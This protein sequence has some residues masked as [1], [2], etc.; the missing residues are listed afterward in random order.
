MINLLQG[1]QEITPIDQAHHFVLPPPGDAIMDFMNE[2]GYTEARLLEFVQAIQT[3]L[4]DKANLGS[5]TKKGWKDKPHVILYC[6]FTK[7]IICH[8]G[9]THNIHQRLVSPFHLAKEDLR[10]GNLK[11]VPKGEEDEVFGMPIPNGLMKREKKKEGEEY[12]VERAIQMSLE[13]YQAQSLSHVGGVAIREPVVEVTRPLPVVEG[14]GK[15]IATEEQAAQSLLALH[16][17]KKRI[18]DS[19]SPA[20]AE[21]GAD[22]DKTNIREKTAEIDEGQ[23][24]SDPGKTP[25]SRPLPDSSSS[26]RDCFRDLPEADMKEML[27][28]RMF[29]SGSYKSHHEHVALYEALEVSMKRAQRGELLAENAKSRKR[30][31]DYQDPPPP[32][33]DSDPSK[34]RRHAFDA[35]QDSSQASY[36][37]VIRPRSQDTDSAHL[38]K[39]KPMPEWLKPIP[40]DDIPETP[41]PDWSIPPNDLP[42]PKNK[43]ANANFTIP[44]KDPEENKLLQK[45]GDMG[46]FITWFC[47]RIC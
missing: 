35:F 31:R 4:T 5:P 18:R 38:H 15:A 9:R 21:T 17:P 16:M 7:L 30:R 11:F 20:D 40:E 37:L 6:R 8:L 43:W 41:E 46:S 29:E 45:T 36:S 2:L 32:Q 39:I 28:Q 24:E 44:S 42:E 3:F 33:Q 47:Q 23:A 34:K 10:L 26:I 19:P 27:H 1:D 25:E 22:T 14:K 12:D 13:S